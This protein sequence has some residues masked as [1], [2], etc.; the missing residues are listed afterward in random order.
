MRK[1]DEERGGEI[2]DDRDLYLRI[3]SIR[4]EHSIANM[5]TFTTA[6]LLVPGVSIVGVLRSMLIVTLGNMVG[7]A[8]LLGWP[9]C[10]MS[11]PKE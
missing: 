8:L 1:Q 9:L 10:K 4:F 5:A 7:G 11:A 2:P 6:M 3:R